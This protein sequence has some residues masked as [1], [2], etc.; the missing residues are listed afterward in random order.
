MAHEKI[1]IEYQRGP[2]VD[3]EQLKAAADAVK[4]GLKLVTE[5]FDGKALAGLQAD[6]NELNRLLHDYNVKLVAVDNGVTVNRF[7]VGD[8]I[9]TLDKGARESAGRIVDFNPDGSVAKFMKSNGTFG[10]VAATWM[11]HF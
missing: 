6:L 2:N 4:K 10:E 11:K 3:V 8:T 9:Q 7:K 5:E 1:K